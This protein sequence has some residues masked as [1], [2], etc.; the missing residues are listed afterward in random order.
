MSK[1][2]SY[3]NQGIELTD[4]DGHKKTTIMV[5]STYLPT[6]LSDFEQTTTVFRSSTAASM[7]RFSK[8]ATILQLV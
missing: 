1:S 3:L 6:D 7:S 4:T 5:S 8:P 2:S